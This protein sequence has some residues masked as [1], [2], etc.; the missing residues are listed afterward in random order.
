MRKLLLLVIYLT[1]ACLTAGSL[2]KQP[3]SDYHTRRETLAKK[4]GGVV[5]LMAPLEAMDSVYEFRQDSNFYYISGVTVPGAAVLIAPATEA[6]DDNPARAYTEFL[7][8]P[9]RNARLEKYTGPQLGADTPDITKTT[10]FDH[11][12]EMSKLPEEVA[13]VLSGGR[14]VI[15]TDVSS[16][17]EP[18]TS[19]QALDFLKRTNTMVFFQ[20]VKPMLS[21]MRT[22]K[23][24][25]EI[26]L[27]KKAVDASAAAHLAAM[28]AV[29]PNVTEYEISGLMQY[30]WTRRGCERPSYAPIVGS[31]HNSTVLHYS[32]DTNTMRSGD[33]VVIDAA[34]EYSM[35]A[36]DITRTLPV[37]GHFTARQLEIYDIVLGAQQ[38]AIDA[39]QSGKSMLVGNPDVSLDKVARDYIKT[40]GK[41]LHGQP[42]DQYFIHGLGHYLGLHV[43]DPG[44]YKV[45]L[46]PGMA[47]TIE[48]GIY[49]PEEN[50]GVR[51][52]DDFLVGQDGKLIK[53][54]AAVPSKAEDV[55]KAMA[56]K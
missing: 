24:A 51:I 52:E 19:V 38:A 8:L 39:F 26:E 45:P 55:E 13:K 23:D 35:Y 7:F 50:I 41:D 40:H 5:V 18:T 44:D 25:G 15:Y 37:D 16:Q 54:S 11:V 14:P 56:G 36:A 53:L 12:E 10:G 27:L 22:V 17:G 30:E 1:V 49:I 2:E 29:K 42:L 47:F 9:P 32:E 28:K 33:V 4:A 3:P 43:H 20:D 6:H 46:G 34:C 48:P 21:S 31:G